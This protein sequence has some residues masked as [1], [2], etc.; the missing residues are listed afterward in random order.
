MNYSKKLLLFFLIVP[1][2]F[3][4]GMDPSSINT[5][6]Q[7]PI[8]PQSIVTLAPNLATDDLKKIESWLLKN[9]KVI[10]GIICAPCY[11]FLTDLCA[12]KSR[13]QAILDKHN[14]KNMSRNSYIF[15]IN[16]SKKYYIKLV[17]PV[18][19]RENY[20]AL[21][22]RDLRFLFMQKDYEDIQKNGAT[23]TYQT[24]SRV[25]HGLLFK[26]W[27]DAW[28]KKK[29]TCPVKTP[30]S[31]LV[32]IPWQPHIVEDNNYVV[33][34]DFVESKGEMADYP[35]IFLQHEACFHEAIKAVGIWDILK[36]NCLVGTDNSLLCVD[37]E[38]PF[39]NNPKDFFY[40]NIA[41]Y[42]K[43]VEIGLMNLA[44]LHT[45]LEQKVAIKKLN[46]VLLKMK[47]D[48]K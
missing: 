36:D 27:S 14:L 47:L 33:V 31:Y 8:T 23:A 6:N 13:I 24:I 26:Q 5:Y 20:N 40:K 9:R 18:V 17:G 3:I 11:G 44:D 15:D 39:N 37:L 41:E 43:N 22:R 28:E 42:K 30:Q 29:G 45:E 7:V 2:L 38:Q 10:D 34:E 25:A 32:H 19:K 16:A 35:E 21:L 1:S 4:K 12:N 46:A 48:T